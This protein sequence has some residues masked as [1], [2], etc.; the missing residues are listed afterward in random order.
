[1]EAKKGV[2]SRVKLRVDRLDITIV[3]TSIMIH[4]RTYDMK[5]SR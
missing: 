5:I 1:M 2:D 4:M 3:T